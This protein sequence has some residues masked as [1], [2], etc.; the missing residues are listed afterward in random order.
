[1]TD[2]TQNQRGTDVTAVCHVRAPLLLEPI[3][4]QIETLRSCEAEGTIDDLLLR[5][6][7][8]EVTISAS[9][10][11]QE[12]LESVDRFD[13]WAERRGVAVRPPFRERTTTSQVTGETKD[14]LVTPMICLEVYVDDEL[15]GVFPHTDPAAEETHTVEEA[16]ATLRTGE[17]PTP[18][19]K[20]RSVEPDRSTTCPD[21]GGELIDGQGLYACSDCGWLGTKTPD[22]RYVAQRADAFEEDAEHTIVR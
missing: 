9:S 5:S 8:K 2:S 13:D 21:C 14:L 20:V 7:P 19:S 18:L 22:G 4:R 12:V 11:Y 16:I 3:D 1:M 15:L 10:P 6:W 17:L